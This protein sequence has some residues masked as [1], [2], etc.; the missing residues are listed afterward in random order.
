[1]NPEGLLAV[2]KATGLSWN[3]SSFVIQKMFYLE[4]KRVK[5]PIIVNVLEK[6]ICP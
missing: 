3:S 6:S 2:E 5:N 4:L 1:M